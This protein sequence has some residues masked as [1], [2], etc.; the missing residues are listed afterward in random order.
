MVVIHNKEGDMPEVST[1]AICATLADMLDMEVEEVKFD[2]W[3][4]LNRVDAELEQDIDRYLACLDI[5]GE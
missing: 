1:L 3:G 4:T 2:L 5:A